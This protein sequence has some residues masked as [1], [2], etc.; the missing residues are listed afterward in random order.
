LDESGASYQELE[1]DELLTQVA[2]ILAEEQVVGW[3]QGPMEFGPR[4]LGGRSIL[5]DPRSKSM[6]SLMNKKIKYRESFRPFAPSVLA[7]R[8]SEYF[9]LDRSSP[10]M[11]LVAQ[12][13]ASSEWQ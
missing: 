7:E 13:Q 11:L 5:G 6:Q 1:E 9:Q 12:L 10:Y 3:F 8:V 2:S 4:A